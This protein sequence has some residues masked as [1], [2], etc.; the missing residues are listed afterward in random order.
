[1]PIHP[2]AARSQFSLSQLGGIV[3]ATSILSTVSYLA[4]VLLLLM[5]YFTSLLSLALL[6]SSRLNARGRYELRTMCSNE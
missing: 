4:I 5:Q 1:M 6:V 3:V 2:S